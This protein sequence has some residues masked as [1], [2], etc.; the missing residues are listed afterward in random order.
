V[1]LAYDGSTVVIEEG[2]PGAVDDLHEGDA[3]M[4]VSE[5][6]KALL[7]KCVIPGGSA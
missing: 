2:R 3:A 5:D 6:G 4:F 7:I 1:T